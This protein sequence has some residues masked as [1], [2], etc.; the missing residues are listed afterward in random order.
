MDKYYEQSD[1]GKFLVAATSTA[2]SWLFGAW[3]VGEPS[4]CLGQF[5]KA[6][7]ARQACMTDEEAKAAVEEL[8]G[9]VN[10]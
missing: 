9:M 1:C 8:K 2:G 3:K 7:E 10:G 6:D 4:K 5:H